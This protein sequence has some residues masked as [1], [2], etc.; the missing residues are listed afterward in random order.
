MA[1][2][3]AVMFNLNFLIV[4]VPAHGATVLLAHSIMRIFIKFLKVL[5]A[6]CVVD[7]RAV[8]QCCLFGEDKWIETDWAI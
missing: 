4:G 3:H 2:K 7:V 8:K 6:L 1:E 5:Q